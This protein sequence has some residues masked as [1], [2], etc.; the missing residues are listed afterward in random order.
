[1]MR[2]D[3]DIAE[4]PASVTPF[5]PAVRCMG[6]IPAAAGEPH[7][8]SVRVRESRATLAV[9][10]VDPHGSPKTLTASSIAYD[11]DHIE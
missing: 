9:Y 3:V 7:Y 8:L 11:P 10:G 2:P 1:M 6:F 5:A 4:L